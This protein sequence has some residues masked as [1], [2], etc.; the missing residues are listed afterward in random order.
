[1]LSLIVHLC[2]AVLASGF[3]DS[4]PSFPSTAARRPHAERKISRLQ[5]TTSKN[6]VITGGTK[7]VGYALAKRFLREGDR[8]IVCGRDA[9]RLAMAVEALR[10][11]PGVANDG[12]KASVGGILC[13][14][15]SPQD[16]ERLGDFCVE[17]LGH[18]DVWVN[19]AGTVAGKRRRLSDLTPDDLKQVLDTNLLGTLLCCKKAIEIMSR[20]EQG[21]HIFNMD[22]AGVEGGATKGYAAYGA[23]KRAMPQLSASIREE[24]K[25]ANHNKIGVHNLSPGMVLTDLLLADSTPA[26]RRF[27]NTLCEEPDTVADYLVPRIRR[28]SGS[29]SYVKFLTIPQA[30]LKLI[31]GWP[32]IVFGGRFFDG[33]GNRVVADGAK[34]SESGVKAQYDG[35]VDGKW[36]GATQI[37]IDA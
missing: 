19:N 26:F 15:G 36:R 35:V 30:V 10:R 8:V 11:D 2:T 5:S 21:G 16:V 6:V 27:F 23:S 7:G 33:D 25:E 31:T 29:G 32:Q 20:Q 34:Y 28:V 22:G 24:L 37:P 4:S 3:P 1:M 14:V 9:D 18:I 17:Q 13:D 12:A